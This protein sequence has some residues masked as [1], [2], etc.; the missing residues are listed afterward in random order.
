MKYAL[1]T[2][3]LL[4]GLRTQVP[5]GFRNFRCCLECIAQNELHYA[6]RT[7]YAREV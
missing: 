7:L 4:F 1:A 2:V 5:G 3:L 6:R